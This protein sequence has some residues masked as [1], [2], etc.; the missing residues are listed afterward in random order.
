MGTFRVAFVLHSLRG[1]DVTAFCAEEKARSQNRKVTRP[2]S[3]TRK[4]SSWDL[5]PRFPITNI[6]FSG[7]TGA[8]GISDSNVRS[9][10][11]VLRPKLRSWV[12]FCKTL[13]RRGG[14]T[15]LGKVSGNFSA[16]WRDGRQLHPAPQIAQTVH[17]HKQQKAPLI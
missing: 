1:R 2:R 17:L 5:S 7:A 11:E 6:P 15:R 12:W 10:A 3:L 9:S 4:Y 13:K 16:D 8:G 14:G